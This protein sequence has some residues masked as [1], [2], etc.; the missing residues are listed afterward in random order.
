MADQ[1]HETVARN[2]A[3]GGVSMLIGG[4]D[5][6]K[7]TLALQAVRHTLAGGRVAV[8]VDADVGNSM[9]GPP[10]CVSMKVFRSMEDLDHLD[11]ADSLHFVGTINPSRLVLQQVLATA[12]M[13][14]RAR[15]S[16]DVV[17]VDTTAVTS[18]VAGETLKYHKTELCRPDRVI[19]LQRGEEMEPV[20]GMLRR[21][22][23]A[24]VTTIPTDPAILPMSPETRARKRSEGFAA[25][26]RP[27]LDRWKVRP[28]VFAPTLPIGLSLARLDGVLVGVQ[29]SD[30]G[31]LGL[32][33]LNHDQD[34][35]RVMTNVG[36][37][38]TG[39]R[40]GSLRLDP[41]TYEIQMLN[42]RE[43]MFGV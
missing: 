19:A 34:T 12:V 39:L 31:C 26:L 24:D 27:P 13:T 38:M 6:G 5:T 11:K 17:I 23:G 10:T 1:T 28:T 36:E 8:L 42:L 40:L 9:V 2:I 41:D 35:L 30:G 14:Q 25:A 37:G 33:V 32:G 3:S 20:V 21:F 16:G 7:T 22:L 18:G 15:E 4:L 29:A 43:V